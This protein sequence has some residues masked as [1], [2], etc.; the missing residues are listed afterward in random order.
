MKNLDNNLLRDIGTLSR[1]I[2]YMSDVENKKYG[3]QK[4]QFIFLTR[5]C[6]NPNINFIELSNMLK[7]DKTTTTKAVNKLVDLNYVKKEIN[8]QDRRAYNL[9]ATEEGKKLYYEIIQQE[10]KQIQ[11]CLEGFSEDEKELVLNFVNRISRN[12]DSEWM[13]I[14]SNK[15]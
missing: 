8:K 2:H 11:I 12:V 5:I 6:E 15:K 7:V 4:G 10:N 14:K 3:L 9:I 1:A 13:K